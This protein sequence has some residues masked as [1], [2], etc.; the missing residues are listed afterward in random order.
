MYPYIIHFI[1]CC[2]Y[3]VLGIDL[4]LEKNY[5]IYDWKEVL[6][7]SC[8]FILVASFLSVCLQ[9]KVQEDRVTL[10]QHYL[11]CGGSNIFILTNFDHT[12]QSLDL[13]L[14]LKIRFPHLK[15]SN[16]LSS[17][18]WFARIFWTLWSQTFF[19]FFCKIRWNCYWVTAKLRL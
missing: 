13:S 17:L 18:D 15:L 3:G 2:L 14:W 4:S 6:F 8:I 12:L 9:M 5:W 11:F 10:E 7:S 19:I 1:D 16:T